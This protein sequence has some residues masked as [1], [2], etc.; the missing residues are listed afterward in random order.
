MVIIPWGLIISYLFAQLVSPWTV[1][2]LSSII[3]EFQVLPGLRVWK[4]EN[5]DGCDCLLYG[6]KTYMLQ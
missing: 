1:S 3:Y 2:L 5:Y 6:M 4:F